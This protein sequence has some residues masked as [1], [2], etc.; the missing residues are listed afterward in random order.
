MQEE[1][2]NTQEEYTGYRDKMEKKLDELEGVMK[3]EKIIKEA[4]MAQ[5]KDRER[6]LKEITEIEIKVKDAVVA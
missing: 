2:K 4:E 1:L 6:R 3:A 5:A